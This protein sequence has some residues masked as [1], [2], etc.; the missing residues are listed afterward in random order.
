MGTLTDDL[1]T[2]LLKGKPHLYCESLYE[3]RN[4]HLSSERVKF[5][6]YGITMVRISKITLNG[7]F[8]VN[9]NGIIKDH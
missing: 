3:Y 5:A 7:D 9:N 6:L 2:G 4:V 8:Y 1:V